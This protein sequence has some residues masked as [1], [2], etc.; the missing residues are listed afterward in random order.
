MKTIFTPEL[1]QP[2]PPGR[3]LEGRVYAAAGRFR[4]GRPKHDHL[5][6]LERVF[7]Q[8]VLFG[9]A[10]PVAESPHVGGAPVPAFP[11]VGVVLAVGE[12]HQVHE[13]EVGA[14]AVAD[15]APRVVR[16]GGGEDGGRSELALHPDDLV[17][18]DVERLVPADRLV[19]G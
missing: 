14:V 4:I 6:V 8:V 19:S 16:A 17:G 18:H 2:L 11:A 13:T 9:Q 15:V 3:A 1:L 12:A 10:Q 7:Q 5:G